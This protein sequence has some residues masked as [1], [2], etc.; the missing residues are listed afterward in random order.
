MYEFLL[1][2]A[3]QWNKVGLVLGIIAALAILF[4]I[5]ILIVTK[6]CKVQE[7]E[8]VLKIL[9]N[10]AGANCGG[11]GHTGCEGF[12]KAVAEG[13][14]CLGDCKVTSTEA[15]CIIAK[16]AGIPYDEEEPT[17]A[18]VKCSGGENAANKYTYIGEHGCINE[19]IVQGGHKSCPTSC[20]G[21]GSCEKVCPVGAIKVKNGLSS[22]DKTL[23][24]SC[25]SCIRICPKNCIERIPA[26]AKVF[27][28][29]S[30]HCK[31]KDVMGA[32]KQG[33]IGCGLC[34]KNCPEQAI[35]MVNNLPVIDYKKCTGCKTCIGKCP[36][37]IIKE[38]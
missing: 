38:L 26:S 30:S 16:V 33:C 22:V 4:G 29:C 12:A 11:C 24:T 32:C 35:T 2:R 31:G 18:V 1:C 21:G 27:I 3:I 8:K 23:C 6:V 15:K 9:E 20:L 37:K 19:I 5:L 17:V 28:A 25:G 13:K 7:D 36:R 10:L 34:A 14:A